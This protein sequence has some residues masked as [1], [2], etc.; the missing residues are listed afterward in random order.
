MESA[1][2]AALVLDQCEDVGDIEADLVPAPWCANAAFRRKLHISFNFAKRDKIR[3]DY[4]SK[5]R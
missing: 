2:R 4:P 1:E 5:V 3:A